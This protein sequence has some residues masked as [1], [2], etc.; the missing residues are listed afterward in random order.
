MWAVPKCGLS[1]KRLARAH[2][3]A[4]AR[5]RSS[6][7]AHRRVAEAKLGRKLR[8]DEVVDHLNEDKADN[9]PINLNVK[10]RSVHTSEHNRTRGLSK[11]RASL[12]MAT[13]GKR[14]Y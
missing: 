10:R 4:M 8:P 2:I 7:T 9:T 12:R 6:D 11:L 5:D 13:E 1:H 3:K 14:L